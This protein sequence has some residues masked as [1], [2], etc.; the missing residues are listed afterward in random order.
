M[1]IKEWLIPEFDHE[2]AVTRQVLERIPDAALT[3][4]PHERSFTLGELATHVGRVVHWGQSILDH[5]HYDLGLDPGRPPAAE[6]SRAAVLA[7][8]D[9]EVAAVRKALS[10]RS[11]AELSARWSV[12]RG[13]RVVMALPRFAA[14]R[15]FVLNHLIHHRGQLT[16]YL[17]LQNV[18]L[19]PIYGPSAAEPM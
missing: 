3:W 12:K 5:D 9:R 2:A 6:G 16:V 14:V 4:K 8:F 10:D 19:P 17:R 1:T 7:A 11:D 18:P 15:R 13:D